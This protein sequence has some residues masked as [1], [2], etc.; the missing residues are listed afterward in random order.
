MK[1]GCWSGLLVAVLVAMPAVAQ[2][3]GPAGAGDAPVVAPPLLSSPDDASAASDVSTEEADDE[4]PRLDSR[5]AH[6][7][8]MPV[9][10]SPPRR[11]RRGLHI[12]LGILLGAAGLALGAGGGVVAGNA[13]TG[14][15]GFPCSDDS[16]LALSLGVGAAL[17]TATGIYLTGNWVGGQG[18]F[19]PTLL[20]ASLGAIPPALLLAHDSDAAVAVGIF[21][22]VVLPVVGGLFGYGLSHGFAV[23][24]AREED[25]P[26][27]LVMVPVF[28]RTR[29][30]SP[31]GGLAG[32]F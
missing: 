28:G 12:P 30:G 10:P 9:A 13:L 32:C 8:R 27:S 18:G 25:A 17:G 20:G 1:T 6:E 16:Q 29:E 26:P 2:E 14:C 21:N 11:Y 4:E 22:L 24:A 5:H 7:P 23:R 19:V 3:A 31:L 15:N